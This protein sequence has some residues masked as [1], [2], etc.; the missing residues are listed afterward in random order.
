MDTEC[1]YECLNFPAENLL[2][3]PLE[4]FPGRRKPYDTF[5]KVRPE[6]CGNRGGPRKA[7]TPRKALSNRASAYFFRF[8]RDRGLATFFL[9]M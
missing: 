6:S 9:R 5:T 1:P 3:L 8:L 2:V 4:L 7:R